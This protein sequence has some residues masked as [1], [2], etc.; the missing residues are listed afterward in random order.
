M[1][2]WLVPLIVFSAGGIGAYLLTGRRRGALRDWLAE[3]FESPEQWQEWNEA[4]LAELERIQQ[5][6][7]QIAQS[8][9]PQEQAGR[10]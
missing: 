2:K 3:L 9:E 6:L 10:P 5:A 4:A 1:R 7:N 8:L